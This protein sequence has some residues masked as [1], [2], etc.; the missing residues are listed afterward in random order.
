MCRTRLTP[1]SQKLIDGTVEGHPCIGIAR[2]RN[3]SRKGGA[4]RGNHME[5]TRAIHADAE[6]RNG[7][8]FQGKLHTKTGARFSMIFF[9]LSQAR[10]ALGNGNVVRTVVTDQYHVA[11]GI[12]GM[13]LRKGAPSSQLLHD[14]H[15]CRCFQIRFSRQGN[16]RRGQKGVSDNQI[17][18]NLLVGVVWL[19]LVIVRKGGQ[20]M[21]CHQRIQRASD[22]CGQV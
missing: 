10:L 18:G 1:T 16:S 4:L 14:Q 3:L 15:G 11:F 6:Q 12:K 20:L 21:I 13:N 8:R 9:Q 19:T 17:G 2:L 5:R 7:T 22:S